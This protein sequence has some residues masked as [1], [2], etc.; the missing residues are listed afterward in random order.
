M[1]TRCAIAFLWLGLAE[2]G[3]QFVAPGGG[4]SAGPTNQTF[5]YYKASSVTCGSTTL[6]DTATIPANTLA[7]GDIITIEVL[8]YTTGSVNGGGNAFIQVAFGSAGLFPKS[9]SG[10]NGAY[11]GFGNSVPVWMAERLIVTGAGTF[12]GSGSIS[13]GSGFTSLFPDNTNASAQ[14]MHLPADALT[15]AIAISHSLYNCGGGGTVQTYWKIR[16]NR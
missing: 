5:S 9:S 2:L 3:A 16:V 10:F 12:Y 4:G 6:L 13:N 15:G 1:L 11:Y 7:V 14:D 8:S